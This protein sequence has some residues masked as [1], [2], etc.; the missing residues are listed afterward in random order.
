MKKKVE[1]IIV[2]QG[3]AGTWLSHELLSRGHDLMVFNH[4]TENTSSNKAAGLY[5]PITGRKMVKTWRADDFFPQLEKD[6]QKLEKLLKS[7]FLHPKPIY[8]PFKNVESQNDWGSRLGDAH[9][10]EYVTGL[11][12]ESLGLKNIKDPLGGI[13]LNRSGYVDLPIMISAYRNLLQAMGC[14]IGEKFNPDKLVMNN[15]TISYDDYVA[16]TVIFCEGVDVSGFWS[17]IPFRPV[18]GEVIDIECELSSPYIINQGVFM[19]P[20]N[21]YF[22]V[23]STYDHVL[24]TYEP[25]QKGVE[26]LLRR[27]KDIFDGEV[28]VKNKKAGVRP[29]THDRKPYI[30]FHKNFKT[31]GIFNGFGTKG[32]SLSPYFAKHFAEVLENKTEIEEEVNVQ[33]VY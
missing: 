6:Y 21:G 2:G 24:L 17:D 14:Y 27:I 33:R 28:R 22:T 32:V 8:R 19:I 4:E 3:I 11:K 12:Q 30:G 25:Q 13:L 16:K 7:R 29:A 9:Y 31:L 18:R 26:T 10:A 15:E 23:G 20:K 5:N 1:Y